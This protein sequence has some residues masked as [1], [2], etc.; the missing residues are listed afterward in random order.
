MHAA[1]IVSPLAALALAPL[2]AG[3]INRVKAWFAGRRGRPTLQLYY[4][5]GKLLRKG[6][7]YSETSSWVVRAGPVVS[8]AAPLCAL[9]LV[10]AG[11]VPSALSFSWDFV[12]VAYLLGLARF[13]TVAAA[14]D[15]GSAFEGMGASR[16]VWLSAL[17]EPALILLLAAASRSVG[18]SGG[19]SA[20]VGAIDTAAW[21]EHAPTLGLVVAAMLIV[22]LAENS[23]VPFDD[24]NTH[25]ELTMVHEA[26]ILDHGGPDLAFI[27]YGASIKMWILASI[28]VGIALPVRTGDPWLDGTAAVAA[29]FAVGV[30]TGVVESTMARFRLARLPILL[31]GAT[32]LAIVAFVLHGA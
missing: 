32:V 15:T 22:F 23:R 14:L 11:G 1:S 25:L 30:F 10:P 6:T 17:A 21:L 2:L 3:V 9:L 16:E 19:L 27:L 5:L 18:A 24:P 20:M 26:M 12:F 7:V 8:L 31:A 29:V 13:F 28:V 4:D